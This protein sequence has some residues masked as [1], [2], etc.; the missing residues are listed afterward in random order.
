MPAQP[1]PTST[2]MQ[3]MCLAV[4]IYTLDT[5]RHC[6]VGGNTGIYQ[7]RVATASPFSQRSSLPC[8]R[9]SDGRSSQPMPS[10]PSSPSRKYLS[11][12][13]IIRVPHVLATGPYRPTTVPTG[14]PPVA[15]HLRA[16]S[17]PSPPW[18]AKQLCQ[19]TTDVLGCVKTTSTAAGTVDYVSRS[20]GTLFPLL[21]RGHSALSVQSANTAAVDQRA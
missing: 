3:V 12:A 17:F 6:L 15:E 1:A 11:S 20:V 8:A 13:D 2:L 16:R 14:C 19:A 10:P 7:C 21:L 9:G 5:R 4:Q 18:L